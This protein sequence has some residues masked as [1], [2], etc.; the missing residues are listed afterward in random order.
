MS[1]SKRS[2]ALPSSTAAATNAQQ[3]QQPMGTKGAS[4]PPL[5]RSQVAE[6]QRSLP[7][8]PARAALLDAVKANRT[9]VLVG[10]TGS[11]KTTQ[12]TQYLYQAGYAGTLEKPQTIA[13]TQPRRVAAISVAKRVAQEV[14]CWLGDK[15]GYTVRFDDCSSE[16]T[17]IKYMTDGMLLREAMSDDTHALEQYSV[18]VLDEAHERTLHTDVLFAVVKDLQRKRQDLRVIVMSATLDAQQFA[19]Y[20]DDARVVYVAG[21]QFPVDTFYLSKSTTDYVDAAFVAVLQLHQDEPLPGDALVF[22]TGQ[23]EIE[24]VARMLNGASR[25]LPMTAAKLLVCTV[26]AA[27]PSHQQMLVFDPPPAGTRKIVLATNIAETSITIPGIKFVIDPGLVKARIHNPRTGSDLLEVIPVSKAQARQR[28]GRAGRDAPGKCYRLYTEQTFN[29]TLED[30]TQPEIKRCN[31]AS[32]VLSL[33]ALG[34]RDLQNF[35]FMDK[36]PRDALIAALEHNYA[37][38]A[39]GDDGELTELGRQMSEFPLEPALAKAL[40]AA[41]TGTESNSNGSNSASQLAN[42]AGASS[43]ATAKQTPSVRDSAMVEVDSR[44]LAKTR[45]AVAQNATTSALRRQPCVSEMIDIVSMLSTENIFFTPS[46]K[47]EQAEAARAPFRAPEGDHITLF[48]VFKAYLKAKGDAEWCRSHFLNQRSMAAA[49]SVRKQLRGLC[50]RLGLALDSCGEHDRFSVRYALLCG[51]ASKT[52]VLQPDNSYRTT[53]SHETVHIHPSSVLF[54]QRPPP[55]CVLFNELVMTSKTYMRDVT[56]VDQ[57]WLAEA[58][59]RLFS[60]K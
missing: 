31:M 55:H 18:I 36:P 9:L 57:H 42:G 52:A 27:L 25:H 32:A 12:L 56:V 10:E 39:L 38:G 3:K 14:G 11:G 43:S 19:A 44:T 6:H 46:D 33:K 4:L 35:D 59:P 53:T 54:Q 5:P 28:A 22:L 20:F 2:V 37:L 48:N 29:E 17:R 45:P 51:F 8:W 60:S 7:I 30:V 16:R 24:A 58:A 47:R 49:E 34:V 15:V 40:I 1:T 21:R 13:C 23:D 26:Y 41:A 50:T